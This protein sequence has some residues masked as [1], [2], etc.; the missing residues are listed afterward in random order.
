M[1]NSVYKKLDITPM[2]NAAGTY[3]MVG[4]SRMS[5]QTLQ[6]MTEAARDHVDIKELQ[7]KVNQK[8]AAEALLTFTLVDAT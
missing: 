5:E 8:L 7:E 3:T 6:D 4:G 1:Q 2:I